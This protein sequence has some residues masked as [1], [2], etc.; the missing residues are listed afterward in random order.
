[1][2]L[3]WDANKNALIGESAVV[4]KDPYQIAVY[5]PRRYGFLDMKPSIA[6]PEVKQY[7]EYITA[8]IVPKTTGTIGWSMRFAGKKS[9]R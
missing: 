8:T 1:M 9:S 7:D 3:R 4:K 5:L 6:Y 2:N